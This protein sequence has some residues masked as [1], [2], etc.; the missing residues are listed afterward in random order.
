MLEEKGRLKKE[1]EKISLDEVE[2]L[3]VSSCFRRIED[4]LDA[5]RE[6]ALFEKKGDPHYVQLLRDFS[7]HLLH[8]RKEYKHKLE[9]H[10]KTLG[11]SGYDI[12]QAMRLQGHC[13]N[14]L[15]R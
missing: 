15:S 1:F 13:D 11:G 6:T 14:R 7:E 8:R 10:R 5:K 4:L 3:Q 12:T 9:E 2:L